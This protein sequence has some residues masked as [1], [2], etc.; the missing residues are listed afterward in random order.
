MNI[1]NNM[2][3]FIFSII[4]CKFISSS[5]IWKWKFFFSTTLMY[6]VFSIL[7]LSSVTKCRRLYFSMLFLISKKNGLETSEYLRRRNCFN[8]QLTIF[9]WKMKL[10]YYSKLKMSKRCM[11]SMQMSQVNI[12]VHAYRQTDK[13]KKEQ[14]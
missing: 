4:S 1:S 13:D 12:H 2:H 5:S 9:F 3:A 6:L 8:Y 7:I 14:I 11:F 10:L